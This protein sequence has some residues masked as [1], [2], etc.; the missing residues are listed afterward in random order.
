MRDPI[1]G[2][3]K[4]AAALSLLLCIVF[5]AITNDIHVSDIQA[6]REQNNARYLEKHTQRIDLYSIGVT[7]DVSGSFVLG[8]GTIKGED[9]Y[10]AYRKL[11]DGGFKYYK[12]KT[13]VTTIYETLESGEQPY[14]EV[15]TDIFG[16]VM[17]CKMY[18]SRN[19]IVRDAEGL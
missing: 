13:N 12:V 19:T 17:E 1:K 16:E 6:V 3:V 18:V 9:Y 5:V 10:C 15:V 7:S 2:A 4:F 14:A 11:D 8:C